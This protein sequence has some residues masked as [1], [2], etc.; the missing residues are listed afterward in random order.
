[1]HPLI[2]VLLLKVLL[3][4]GIVTA[5][6]DHKLHAK[7]RPYP[8]WPTGGYR[9]NAKEPG[10]FKPGE[11][12]D[13]LVPGR[14]FIEAPTEQCLGFRW[15]IEGD[16]N[17]NAYV[18]IS[19]RK[20]GETE[21]VSALPMLRV[22]HE[23]V[24]MPSRN[25]WR[26]GN[27]FAG[28]I[29]FL[30][31]G[32]AYEVRLEMKDPDGGAPS[33]KT[34]DVSTRPEPKASP[35]GRRLHVSAKPDANIPDHYG[36]V[37][38]AFKVAQPGDTILI[39]GGKYKG[40]FRLERS[41]QPGKPIVLK[42]T[43]DGDVV[44]EAEGDKPLF[45]INSASHLFFENL[46]LKARIGISSGGKHAKGSAGIVIRR[47]RFIGTAYAISTGSEN[48]SNWTVTDNEI[49][50]PET[51]WY[52]YKSNSKSTGVNLYGRG[53]IVAYNRIR[54]FGDCLAIY[55]F[56]PP[57]E[58]IEKHCA[59]IDFYHNDLSDAWDDHIET[60]YGVH[61]VRVWR[62]RC[63]NAHTGLSVQ[64][65]YG[66]PVYLIRNEVYGVTNL[67]FKLN[68]FPA[69]I[70]IYNNTVCAA[71]CAGRIGYAQNMH[72]R[73]NLIL[74]GIV[75]KF[76]EVFK[77]D[78]EK[79][80]NRRRLA[81]A[82]WGGTMTPSRS[83]MDYNGYDRGR[84]PNIPFFNWRSGR[85]SMMLRSL[86]DFRGFTGYESHGLLVDYS[87]F[88]R[89][90]PPKVGKSYKTEDYSLQLK[91]GSSP[92]DAGMNLPNVTDTF[93]G[94]APDMGCHEAGQPGPRYGPR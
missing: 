21:W 20:K 65:F 24:G 70:E 78:A 83:T 26:A 59:A 32:T 39:H 84:D 62:N 55:N 88:E 87:I 30:D 52:P 29:M 33:P 73:N 19:Y 42:G 66:G 28:S 10:G 43:D 46:T 90:S 7:P 15:Y 85:Q 25:P 50:G 23:I 9:K 27:L 17:R 91:K 40:P 63:R 41:G 54:R 45:D 71:T 89:A 74:G 37:M 56:G 47:C 77:S 92:I 4:H 11:T 72:F 58:D 68:V 53:H 5:Q 76:L 94:K 16:S 48:S 36:D 6:Q 79:K 3:C 44:L 80:R 34:V 31:P 82:L 22:H 14:F 75:E 35:G 18:L 61:N 64:P 67:T 1:M 69:G 60:D 57:V 81:H 51:S 13:D 86:R 93:N 8:D 38:S 2:S 12:R 49:T